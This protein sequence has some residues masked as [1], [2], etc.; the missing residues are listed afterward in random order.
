MVDENTD[1]ADYFQLIESVREADS[2]L[3]YK[4]FCT[5]QRCNNE[6][7]RTEPWRKATKNPC[8]L[9]IRKTKPKVPPLMNV[10]TTDA[11]SIGDHLYVYIFTF[12]YFHSIYILNDFQNSSLEWG[13]RDRNIANN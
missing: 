9:P 4:I 1:D 6:E 13:I 5:Q 10:N 7:I 3:K 8:S 11:I 12:I 2:Q